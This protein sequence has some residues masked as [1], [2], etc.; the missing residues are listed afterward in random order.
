M[1]IELI[2]TV[3]LSASG[4]ASIINIPQDGKDLLLIVNDRRDSSGIQQEIRFNADA[5]SGAY[6]A[7]SY[8]GN[9]G[10]VESIDDSDSAMKW[11]TSS[12]SYTANTFGNA[13]LYISDYTRAQH[14]T[15]SINAVSE[16]NASTAYQIQ[17][18]AVWQNTAAINRID[19]LQTM[20]AGSIVSLYKIS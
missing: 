11:L 1:A 7:I 2:E 13:E 15:V 8:R 16:T 3:E 20:T 12:N 14:K 18:A 5:T 10:F 4:T 6:N 17:R 19:V 9:G